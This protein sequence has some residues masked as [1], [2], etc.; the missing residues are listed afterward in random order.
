MIVQ[1]NGLLKVVSMVIFIKETYWVDLKY[2][3]DRS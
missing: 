1:T 2:V 3:T